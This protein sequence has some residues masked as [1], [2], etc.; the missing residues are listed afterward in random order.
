[1]SSLNGPQGGGVSSDRGASGSDF[2]VPIGDDV[3][4]TWATKTTAALMTEAQFADLKE[5]EGLYVVGVTGFSGQWSEA[6]IAADEEIR[7]DALAATTAIAEF[8]SELKSIHGDKLVLSSGA[9][10]EGVPKIIYELC[11]QMGITAMGVTS[12]KA[13]D[14]PLGKMSYLIVQGADWGEESSTFLSTSDELLMVGGGGQAK[15]EAVAACTEGKPV[16]IFQ[17]YKG[18]ADQLTLED[19]PNARFVARH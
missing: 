2:G 19:A 16:T 7:G 14:Y 6:K 18:T 1:M 11:D 15:R 3:K 8:L 4:E 5:R 12:A 17:G 10:M 9:T 13:F